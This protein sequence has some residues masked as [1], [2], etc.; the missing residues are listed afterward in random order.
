[1]TTK[2]FLDMKWGTAGEMTVPD[3]VLGMVQL[4][5]F[6][7]Y[8]MAVSDPIRF[9]NQVVGVQGMYSTA[10][11]NDYLRGIMLSEIASVFGSVMKTRSSARPGGAA[12]RHGRGHPGQGRRTTS[13]RSASR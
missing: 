11:I 8:S 2:D 5:A 7:T 13:T 1:M 3:S 4:R 12:G 6:G 9:V 10:Q